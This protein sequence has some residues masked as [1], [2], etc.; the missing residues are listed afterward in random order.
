MTDTSM[1][2][3]ALIQKSDDGDFLKTI[4][5]VCLQRI[6][7]QDV[8]NVIGAGRHERSDDR[9]TYRN[10]FRDRTLETRLGTLD[11]KVPKLRSGSSYFPAFLE[12]RRLIENALTAVVQEAWICGVST[13]KVEDLVQAMGMSG[14]SKSQATSSARKSTNA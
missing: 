11:L 1:D 6:M 10:G 7:E 14:I 13:R 9:V 8:E 2:F 3:L 4:A 5:E 12:P